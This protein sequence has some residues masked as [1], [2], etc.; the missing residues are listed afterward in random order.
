[1]FYGVAVLLQRNVSLAKSSFNDFVKLLGTRP[2]NDMGNLL[3]G[4]ANHSLKRT[5]H[6]MSLMPFLLSKILVLTFIF[7]AYKILHNN[8]NI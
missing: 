5:S 8:F 1:M 7:A 4:V 2:S 3:R 6:F